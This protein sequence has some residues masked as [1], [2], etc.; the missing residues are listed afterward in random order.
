[1]AAELALNYFKAKKEEKGEEA[2]KQYDEVFK[3]VRDFLF[4]KH[5]LPAIRG[6]RAEA[7]QVIKVIEEGLPRAKDY[8]RDLAQII[9]KYDGIN[10]GDLKSIA[11]LSIK[12][13][14]NA[15]EELRSIVPEHQIT[16]INERVARLESEHETIVLSEDIR[17]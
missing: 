5:P 12:N 9:K 2:D 17:I 13:I 6:R 4:E 10:E 1:M 8:C 14:E 3:L 16:S 7:L 11:Q 15:Y